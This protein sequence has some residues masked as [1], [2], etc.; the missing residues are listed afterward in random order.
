MVKPSGNFND[1]CRTVNEELWDDTRCPTPT[2]TRTTFITTDFPG[3]F[4]ENK[5]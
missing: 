4:L 5:K 2:K 3:N 1:A